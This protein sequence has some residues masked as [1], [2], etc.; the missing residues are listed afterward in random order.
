MLGIGSVKAGPGK[1]VFL[2]V[3]GRKDTSAVIIVFCGLDG[4][5]IDFGNV[6]GWQSEPDLEPCAAL[7]EAR[8]SREPDVGCSGRERIRKMSDESRWGP[9][10]D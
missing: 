2:G 1:S 9:L 3:D 5:V 4:V 8:E 10:S 7:Q 6:R